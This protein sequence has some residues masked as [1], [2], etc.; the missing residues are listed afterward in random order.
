MAL[1]YILD[2]SYQTE[3]QDLDDRVDGVLFV[4][5]SLGESLSESGERKTRSVYFASAGDRA[6]ARE[7]L[8][9]IEDIELRD[10]DRE[11]IDWL[12]K[13]EQSLSAI[14]IGTR[15]VV[16]PDRALIGATDRLTIVIPQEQAF[17][18]GSHETTALCL[19]MLESVAVEGASC[20]DIGTGSGIL[21]IAM[22][23]LGA[24]SVV[25]FDNDPEAMPVLLMNLERN[26]ISPEAIR[27]FCGSAESLGNVEVD[28]ATMNILP[29]V[30]ILLLPSVV[31]HLRSGA[32]LILSGVI[33]PKRDEV[34][35]AAER[36]GL[37]LVREKSAGE[38]WCG[39]VT[40]NG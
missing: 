21:A 16:A 32:Q 9:D 35:A 30:I 7:M 12:E 33:L 34:V 8:G 3:R 20:A 6:G 15:F 24:K 39:V 31:P 14:E 23:M 1:D 11:R 5:A 18:T 19:E 36:Q 27:C 4:T 13:Y 2:I 37:A 22:S 25:A 28:V 29:D 17:G 26:G 38:W 10:V 40:R